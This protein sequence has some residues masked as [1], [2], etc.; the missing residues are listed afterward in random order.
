MKISTKKGDAG[1]TRTLSG[2]RI[3]KFHLVTETA[4]AID[5]ANS[6][7]GLARSS[8]KTKRIKRILLQVQKHLF[9]V[10]AELSFSKEKGNPLKKTIS[11]TDVKWLELLIE[12]L[13]EAL[14]L[15]PGFV[16][17]GQEENASH[18]DV[19]RTGIRR[20]ERLI[21]RM[22]SKGMIGNAHLLKYLNRLSD[23]IFLLAC[24]EEKSEEERRKVSKKLF[25]FRLDDSTMRR[26]PI[27][28]G[29]IIAALISMIVL[30]LVF[31][32]PDINPYSSYLQGHMEEMSKM[33][34]RSGYFH[35]WL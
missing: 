23:L 33:H 18:L 13:E 12:D 34:N 22:N 9:V 6:L 2:E 7:L 10:G 16:A 1:Y 26:L 25:A 4:G 21:V 32:K 27:I 24:L 14:A 31:H 5:E 3:S 30:I 15:P 20:A 35:L 29:F 11:E 8:V 19:A 17:F 28:A